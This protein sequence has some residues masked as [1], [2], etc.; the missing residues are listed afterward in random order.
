MI[1]GS[2]FRKHPRRLL[3]KGY[4]CMPSPHSHPCTKVSMC[5]HTHAQTNASTHGLRSHAFITFTHSTYVVYRCIYSPHSCIHSQTNVSTH[6]AYICIYS[7]HSKM[8]AHVWPTDAFTRHIHKQM[9]GLQ[10]HAFI[11]FT[12]TCTNMH[13]HT[14]IQ[15]KISLWVKVIK[16]FQRGYKSTYMHPPTPTQWHTSTFA[17][18]RS[19]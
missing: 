19:S 9:R 8:W 18:S 1:L 3:T 4:G 14:H 5:I 7:P 6:V 2:L 11:T 10:M 17:E 15:Y 13:A 16:M 12:H